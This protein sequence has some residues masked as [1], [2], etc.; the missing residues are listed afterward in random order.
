MDTFVESQIN[1]L[2]EALSY[3][4]KITSEHGETMW[5]VI[6]PEELKKIKEILE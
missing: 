4:L 1:K 5:M 6:V 2:G 3:K